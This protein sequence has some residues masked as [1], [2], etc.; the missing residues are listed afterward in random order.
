VFCPVDASGIF[1]AEAG[2]FEGLKVFEANE[3]IIAALEEKGKLIAKK[4][5][6]H[7]YPHCW[8]CKQPI[9]FRAT[10]QW[11]LGIDRGNLREKLIGAAGKVKWVP[12]SGLERIS[13]MI[14]QRPDWCLSRQRFWGTPVPVLYCE[15]CGRPQ[16]DPG[17]LRHIENRVLEEGTDFWFAEPSGKIAP[18]N[19]KCSCGCGKFRK[20]TDILDVWLD[21]GISWMAVMEEG[22]LGKEMYPCDLYLE[23]SD[24]HRGWFQTSLIPSVALNGKAPY[25]EVLTHGF[26]LDDKGRAM[27]K[28]VGN[29]VSPQEI[30]NKYGAEILRLWVTLSD[31]CDDIRISE[32]LLGVPVD[33]YRKI[34]NTLRYILGNLN[35]FNP[36]KNCV[37]HDKLPEMELYIRHKL[38]NL[39]SNVRRRYE[40]HEYRQAMRA[41]ADFCILDLSAFYLDATKDAIYTL[42]DDDLERRGAQTVL[43]D[44]FVSLTVM[45]SPVLSFTC[46]E[47]W[48]AARNEFDSSLPESVFLADMP[49]FK[50][51]WKND[52]LE[53]KWLRIM[54]A[55]ERALKVI[56]DLRKKGE[57][58]SSLEAK[59]IFEAPEDEYNFMLSVRDILKKAAIVS[60]IEVEK[61]KTSSLI[62]YAR[63]SG[64]VKCPRCWQWKKDVASDGEYMDLCARCVAVLKAKKN[65]G[66]LS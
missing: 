29:A 38:N 43:H 27:H 36:A 5:L 23:G 33:L 15:R 21:S 34:R 20:E 26:V 41:M 51:K 65:R 7:S 30:Y 35:D 44:I 40:R 14:K 63:R 22:T 24:Q 18:E 31:Y 47:A 13:S 49:E 60:E 57:I 11:F 64:G 1:T 28:S 61:G 39:I 59:V 50:E 17:L 19:Y 9:I 46:E 32:K 56:E 8:R 55:R 42:D 12:S 16:K 53:R 4:S 45:L 6:S 3:K 25:K 37:P 52:N 58:G 66:V 62:A 54:S 2:K 48:R 10:H